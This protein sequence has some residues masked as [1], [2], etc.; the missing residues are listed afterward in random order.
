MNKLKTYDLFNIFE[1]KSNLDD[2]VDNC[3]DIL[4]DISDLIHKHDSIIDLV[5]VSSRE[6]ANFRRYIRIQFV[7]NLPLNEHIDDLIRLN[8]YLNSEGFIFKNVYCNGKFTKQR[9]NYS[10]LY[11][12]FDTIV[13]KI[14]NGEITYPDFE[15]SGPNIN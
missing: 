9:V 15:W 11:Y 8:D 5:R 12:E 4:I 7:K 2:I 10:R 6:V 13:R 14:K 1:S 3:N